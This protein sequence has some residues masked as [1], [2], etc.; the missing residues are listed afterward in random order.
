MYFFRCT[1]QRDWEYEWAF[2]ACSKAVSLRACLSDS[3]RPDLPAAVI[4]DYSVNN[5][6]VLMPKMLERMVDKGLLA[7]AHVQAYGT[8]V[9]SLLWADP[10]A[11]VARRPHQPLL[12]WPVVPRRYYSRVLSSTSVLILPRGHVRATTCWHL[13]HRSDKG[14]LML[15]RMMNTEAVMSVVLN[16]GWR[17]LER[18]MRIKVLFDLMPHPLSLSA[19]LFSINY[20]SIPFYQLK[21]LK[22]QNSIR[23]LRA[24]CSSK[25][26]IPSEFL[27]RVKS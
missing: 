20:M 26:L 9:P 5:S 11:P 10:S 14:S 1:I 3:F 22:I 12:Y 18:D 15:F 7:L 27:F 4:K 25:Q 23:G 16:P 8:G 2:T 6:L 21:G 13:G 19:A 24:M 17:K